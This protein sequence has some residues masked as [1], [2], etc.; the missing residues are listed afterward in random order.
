VHPSEANSG[1]WEDENARGNTRWWSDNELV[2]KITGYNAV[3]FKDGYVVLDPYVQETVYL[4]RMLGDPRD[5]APA[6]RA[7]AV[8]RGKFEA[9][10]TPNQQWARNYPKA[11]NL[12]GTTTRI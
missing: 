10:G 5:F 7:L 2:N 3:E 1:F 8:K 4:D 12:S 6:D 11:N 9:D